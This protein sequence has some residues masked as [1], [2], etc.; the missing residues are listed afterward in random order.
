MIR[1]D[2]TT[3]LKNFNLMYRECRVATGKSSKLQKS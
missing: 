2:E 3:R 1:D